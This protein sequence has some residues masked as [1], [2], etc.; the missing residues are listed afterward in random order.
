[1][2][3]P[4]SNVSPMTNDADRLPE[5]TSVRGV[6]IFTVTYLLAATSVAA[7]GKTWEFM[8]YIGVVLIF[9]FV[10][11]HV[12][13]QVHLSQGVMWS[14][15][16]WG[17]V[18]MLGGLMP[19]PDGWPINGDQRVLYSLWLIP[20]LLKY[21]HVVHAYG[22]GVTTWVCWEGIRA[23]L[24][25]TGRLVAPT[26]GLMVL[27]AAAGMGFGAL[28]EII[29]FAATLLVPETNVGGY[30]NTGWD[31]VANLVGAGVAA[32]L[33]RFTYREASP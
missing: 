33:I 21:D 22:F 5:A 12:H 29:E 6:A 26:F 19:V 23:A 2:T 15:S 30:V 31:L 25:A 11:L 1:M 9:G 3:L 10:T 7:A 28:N 32:A 14:L 4:P 13:R 24:A 17:L 27:A 8:L 20:D 16:I 18:H